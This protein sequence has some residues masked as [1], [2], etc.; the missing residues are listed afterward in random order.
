MGAPE[1]KLALCAAAAKEVDILGSF[2]YANTFPLALSLLASKRIDVLPLITHR[3][4]WTA[5]QLHEGFDA[6]KNADKQNAIKVMF[7][8]LGGRA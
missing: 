4:G 2:R 1:M 8:N 3:F 5:A 6:A 7:R